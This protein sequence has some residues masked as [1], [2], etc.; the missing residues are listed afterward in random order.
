[1]LPNF[2]QLLISIRCKTNLHVLC[3]QM[4]MTRAGFLSWH[5]FSFAMSNMKYNLEHYFCNFCFILRYAGVDLQSQAAYDLASKGLVKPCTESDPLIYSIKCT[6]FDLP[7][8]T[9][10]IDFYCYC[11]KVCLIFFICLFFCK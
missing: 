3:C 4:P 10:G 8:F 7:N 11:S 6:E 1:M 9:L 2:Q 5:L